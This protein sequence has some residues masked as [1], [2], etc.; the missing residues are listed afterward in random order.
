MT[1]QELEQLSGLDSLTLATLAA[2][3]PYGFSRQT[4]NLE[5][6]HLR[7]LAIIEKEISLDINVFLR[8]EPRMFASSQQSP[9]TDLYNNYYGFQKLTTNQNTQEV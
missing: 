2:L 4:L 9:L 8:P 7:K 3:T 6:L 1:L 5:K